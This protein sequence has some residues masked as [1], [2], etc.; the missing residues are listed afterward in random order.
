VSKELA[1]LCL[2]HRPHASL[3]ALRPPNN[4]FAEAKNISGADLQEKLSFIVKLRLGRNE[5]RTDTVQGLDPKF[6]TDARLPVDCP[7]TDML[8]VRPKRHLRLPCTGR[9]RAWKRGTHA[10]GG[11]AHVA[12]KAHALSLTHTWQTQVE[13]LQQGPRGDLVLGS[14]SLSVWSLVDRGTLV[15][16]MELR[17]FGQG[18]GGALGARLCLVLR[19]LSGE[20]AR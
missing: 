6:L 16:W 7:D 19:Y 12:W 20:A 18:A 3:R 10:Q 1:L 2:N 17:A 8:R 4:R 15:H 5:V 11:R 13:M 9:V 14:A